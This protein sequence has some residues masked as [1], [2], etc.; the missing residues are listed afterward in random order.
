MATRLTYAHLVGGR[1]L[2]AGELFT[3][4][5]SRTIVAQ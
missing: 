2:A 3:H 4:E 1:D 5:Q